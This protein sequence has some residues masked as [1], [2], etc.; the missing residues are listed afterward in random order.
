M[1]LLA[2]RNDD[3]GFAE[4]ANSGAMHGLMAKAAEQVKARAIATAPVRNDVYRQSF[5]AGTTTVPG[6][7]SGKA[8]A[9]GKVQ[10]HA[11]HAGLVEAKTANMRRAAATLGG[12]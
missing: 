2:Y 4:L 12:V 9:A 1:T 10:N 11:T 7:F 3:A 6:G 8:R 5:T